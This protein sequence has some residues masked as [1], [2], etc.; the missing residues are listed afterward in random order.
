MAGTW[1]WP[2]TS[3]RKA[4]YGMFLHYWGE[5]THFIR[6]HWQWLSEYYNKTLSDYFLF[7][8]PSPCSSKN[9]CELHFDMSKHRGTALRTL[10]YNS[11]VSTFS[12]LL[13]DRSD[14]RKLATIIW[15]TP[16]CRWVAVVVLK[17]DK[18]KI[19]THLRKFCFS[20]MYN[21]VFT[22]FMPAGCFIQ[23]H[24]TVSL[25]EFN[26]N[27]WKPSSACDTTEGIIANDSACAYLIT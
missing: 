9:I 1:A 20:Q 13:W 10:N 15:A 7:K 22:R 25:G 23:F 18:I 2:L 3:H 26:A 8:T 21:F 14:S 12:V 19:H 17:L 24:F 5:K 16:I 27:S 6:W 4:L 11:K